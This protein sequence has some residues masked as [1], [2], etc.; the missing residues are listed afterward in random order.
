M[1]EHGWGEHVYYVVVGMDVEEV[2]H[3]KVNGGCLAEGLHN[4]WGVVSS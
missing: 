4:C 1:I 3:D 2:G